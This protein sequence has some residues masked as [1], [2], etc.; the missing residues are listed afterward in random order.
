MSDLVFSIA[1]LKRLFS[2]FSWNRVAPTDF[3]ISQY[4]DF[5][6]LRFRASIRHC[7]GYADLGGYQIA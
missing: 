6:G 4:L 5:Y 2:V 1:A 3:V 7:L